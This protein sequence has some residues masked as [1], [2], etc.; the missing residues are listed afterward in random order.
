MWATVDY[1]V[2]D[3]NPLDIFGFLPLFIREGDDG[4]HGSKIDNDPEKYGYTLTDGKWSNPNMSYNQALALTKK[5]YARTDVKEK[6][7]FMAAT[8][9]GR[10]LSLGYSVEEIFDRIRNTNVS[11]APADNVHVRA[12]NMKLAYYNRLL[13]L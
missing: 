2:S 12:N 8:W 9:I 5:I 7:K 6:T 13:E 1:L 11:I 10:I 4:R 3:Q